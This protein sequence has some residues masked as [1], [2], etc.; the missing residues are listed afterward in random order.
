MVA[1]VAFV[2]NDGYDLLQFE[3]M[4]QPIYVAGQTTAT[5]KDLFRPYR[6]FSS[7]LRSTNWGHSDYKG[8]EMSLQRRFSK[9]LGFG[10]AYTL[11][12][13]NDLMS[14]FHSGATSTLYLLKPQD[15]NNPEAEYANSDFD[16]R[17]RFTASQI[18]EL[19]FG[20]N[21]R[22][23]SKGALGH[24]VGGWTLTSLWTF[25]TGF[26]YNVFDGADPCLRAGGYTA[27]CRPN[28]I[29]DPDTGPK[30]AA[31]W[32]NTAAYQ[33]TP[34]GQ[35]GSAPRNSFRGPGLANTDVALIKRVLL[36]AVRNGMN[37][38]LRVETF[39]LF[40]RVN[41]GVPNLNIA[42]G[43]FGRIGST[44]TDA[45]EFQLAVKLNF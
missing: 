3:E 2:R 5:N 10:V 11:S 41:F 12:E 29:G 9:G 16:A 8:L 43:T 1:E 45:R 15:S 36:D 35:F 27:S 24:V 25:Q 42:S 21:R 40:N 39:N 44:A 20:P 23:L 32:F 13:S 19:P 34:I 38:E 18:W 26:P 31:Q 14:G 4:N 17:H 33:R 30:T 6:G 37:L 22:W 7:V 28:L